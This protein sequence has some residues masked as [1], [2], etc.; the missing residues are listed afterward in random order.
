MEGSTLV[1]NRMLLDILDKHVHCQWVSELVNLGSHLGD[2][3]VDVLYA[4]DVV[5]RGILQS[6]ICLYLVATSQYCIV[7]ISKHCLA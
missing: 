6:L 5:D 4:L 1:S 2:N 7:Y 3:P